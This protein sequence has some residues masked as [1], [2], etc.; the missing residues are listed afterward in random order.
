M[1]GYQCQEKNA[2]ITVGQLPDCVSD[3]RQMK[4]LFN[5]LID[6]AIKY[7]SPEKPGKISINGWVE[8]QKAI[9]C[10]EDNGIGIDEKFQKR[11]FDIYYQMDRENSTGQGLGLTIIKRIL[12]RHDG[13][14]RVESVVGVGSKFY[15][16]VPM[17]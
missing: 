6:N 3:E 14:I 8:G 15:I 5:N 17:S 2:E 12:D 16:S 7:L 1:V 11:I 4:Q 13:E 9:Y 10:I